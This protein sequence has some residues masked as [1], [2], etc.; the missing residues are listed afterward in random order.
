MEH[1][2]PT[3]E[4]NKLDQDK[5]NDIIWAV[6]KMVRFAREG[7]IGNIQINYFKGGISNVNNTF[8]DKPEHRIKQ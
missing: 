5:Q 2:I 6:G 7:F 4:F 3:A 1:I 8:S